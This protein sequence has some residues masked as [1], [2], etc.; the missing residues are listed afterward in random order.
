MFVNIFFKISIFGIISTVLA[1]LGWAITF[2]FVNQES[3]SL[4]FESWI[5]RFN[6][7]FVGGFGYGLCWFVLGNRKNLVQQIKSIFQIVNEETETKIIGYFRNILYSKYYH[8][9]S[10]IITFLGGLVL[11]NSGFPLDGFPKFYLAISVISMYY[12][13]SLLLVFV[14]YILSLFFFM[15]KNIDSFKI[16]ENT[17]IIDI[18]LFNSFFIASATVAIL[19]LYFGLRGTI[20][21]NFAHDAVQYKKFLIL[22]VIIYLPVILI[23][24]FYPRYIIK[25]LHENSILLKIRDFEKKYLVYDNQTISNKEQ[26]E[27]EKLILEIKEKLML[28]RAK[29]SILTLKDS[30][31][32]LLS[33]IVF[34]QFILQK[35][36]ALSKFFS[37]F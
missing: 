8:I 28:E 32:L 20:T 15:E 35:D 12:V 6:G 7:I 19:A 24:S 2:F 4:F 27:L 33:I 11:W 31:S 9:I 36:G 14:L 34:I 16:S 5:F 22:P 30:P 21:A 1:L 37:L 18:E 25:K 23:Y 26:L 10:L 13:A 29:I 3:A 17:S